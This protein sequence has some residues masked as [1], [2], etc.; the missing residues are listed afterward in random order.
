MK[1]PFLQLH[2]VTAAYGRRTVLH[3]TTLDIAPND[4]IIISGPN[5]GGKTTLLKI[6]A[7]LLQPAAGLQLFQ[8]GTAVKAENGMPRTG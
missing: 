4:F 6:L 5:G 7:G 8:S 1:G 3:G 2:D